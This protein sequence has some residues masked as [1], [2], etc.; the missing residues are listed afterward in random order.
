MSVKLAQTKKANKSTVIPHLRK[1]RTV[2]V[3]MTVEENYKT[4]CLHLSYLSYLVSKQQA[5]A[6]QKSI[7]MG[8]PQSVSYGHLVEKQGYFGKITGLLSLYFFHMLCLL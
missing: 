5:V 7:L 4:F 1:G 8:R 6:N 2:C 3:R